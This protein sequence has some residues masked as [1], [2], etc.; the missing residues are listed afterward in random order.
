MNTFLRTIG[1]IILIVLA[2]SLLL[3]LVNAVRAE[4]ILVCTGN[5]VIPTEI[6]FRNDFERK[7]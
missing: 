2:A 1:T 4:Y 7:P 5:K 6:L 3:A